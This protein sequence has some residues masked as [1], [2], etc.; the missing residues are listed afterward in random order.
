MQSVGNDIIDLRAIDTQRSNDSRFYSKILSASELALYQR[1]ECA[2]IPFEH[3]LWLLWSIKESGYKYFKRE[4]PGLVF[5]PLKIIIQC[6]NSPAGNAVKYFKDGQWEGDVTGEDCYQGSCIF[7]N[8]IFYFKS[9]IFTELIATVVS[10]DEN[11]EHT[12]WGIQTIKYADTDHQSKEVRSFFLKRLNVFIPDNDL[13]IEKDTAG[14]PLIY[15]GTKELK[16]PVSFA[17]H[18]HFI[19]YSFLLNYS[20]SLHT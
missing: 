12:R 14:Y 19:A 6:I 4:V 17:H 16:F 7:N 5:S 15:S 1:P 9:K 18:A 20:S 3:F 10:E 11:F 13:R 2:H 8:T